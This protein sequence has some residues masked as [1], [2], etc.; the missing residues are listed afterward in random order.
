ML[1]IFRRYGGG[2]LIADRESSALAQELIIDSWIKQL[3]R[4]EQL[5]IHADRGGS[6]TAKPVA[7]A[8]TPCET[9]WR[10]L[11]KTSLA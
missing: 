11:M 7:P 8:K 6:M 3:I 2:W 10:R 9:S 1:D 5:T 4:P